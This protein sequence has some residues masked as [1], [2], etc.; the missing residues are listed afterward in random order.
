[1]LDPGRMARRSNRH[2]PC[3]NFF[4]FFAV[5]LWEN[6]IMHPDNWLRLTK[7]GFALAVWAATM[8]GWCCSTALGQAESDAAKTLGHSQCA[9][10]H[11]SEVAAWLK[12]PHGSKS[13]KMLSHEKAPEFAKAMGVT[14]ALSAS[15]CANCHATKTAAA[16]I[17]EGVSCERC[18]GAAGPAESGW[19]ALHS[20]FG[21]AEK[22]RLKETRQH[23]A[24]RIAESAKLGMNR[25]A[26]VYALAKNCLSCHSVP[27][28][29]LV[30][31]GH[32]TT[33]RFEMVEWSQGE[34]RHNFQLDQK[35]NAQSPS[36]WLDDHWNGPGRTAENRK[37][38][39]V[40]VGQLVDLEIS[41]RNRAKATEGDFGTAAG[42]RITSTARSLGK[43]QHLESVKQVMA[44]LRSASISRSA[45]K[46]YGTGDAKLFGTAA[47][48][49][50]EVAQALATNSDGSD[51]G[52]IKVPDDAKGDVFMP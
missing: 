5:Q 27:N 51:L 36:L 20:K 26:D 22:D 50:A 42:R 17:L 32:P 15:M 2:D 7:M 52:E 38:L 21:N 30:N 6:L 29:K 46:T 43:M 10:C 4:A 19:F 35:V 44:I 23:R 14:G 34:V 45:L 25:S 12:S 1:M 24:A 18:H 47:D 41:L 37:K 48:K 9:E 16:T 8:G 49:V 11:K 40:V 39:M 13:F 28:E 33:K 31:A 3:P